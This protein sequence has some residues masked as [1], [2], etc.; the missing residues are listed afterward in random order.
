ME[1]K[2]VQC[3]V[4]LVEARVVVS[5]LEQLPTPEGAGVCALSQF[6]SAMH[7]AWVEEDRPGVVNNAQGL[8]NLGRFNST[9]L[10]E[11]FRTRTKSA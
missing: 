2:V 1:S 7:F 9:N 6:Q 4:V 8:L 11:L 5:E 10:D 3:S